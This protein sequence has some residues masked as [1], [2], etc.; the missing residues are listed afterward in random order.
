MKEA[1]PDTVLVGGHQGL[2]EWSRVPEGHGVVN[3]AVGDQDVA[4]QGGHGLHEKR[5]PAA[6]ERLWRHLT[7]LGRWQC[8]PMSSCRAAHAWP[9]GARWFRGGG[10]D[11][12]SRSPLHRRV[13]L[14]S[15]GGR[16]VA[17]PMGS[18]TPAASPIGGEAHRRRI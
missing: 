7:G 10:P 8:L 5:A 12:A 6:L 1:P 15:V 2:D 11:A 4:L 9:D 14:E 17:T 3:H 16:D 18:T 13:S